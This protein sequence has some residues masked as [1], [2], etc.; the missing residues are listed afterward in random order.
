MTATR[1]ERPPA[2]E[3]LVQ[4]EL[5]WSPSPNPRKIAERIAGHVEADHLRTVLAGAL[6]Y[7]VQKIVARNR[8]AAA[9]V[10]GKPDAKALVSAPVCTGG[11][12]WSRYGDLTPAEVGERVAWQRE[13]ARRAEHEAL[14]LEEVGRRVADEIAAAV[15]SPRLEAVRHALNET[16]IRRCRVAVT[17]APGRIAEAQA[18]LRVAAES[19][20][21]AKEELAAETL[22]AEWDLDARFVTEANKTYLVEAPCQDPP[23]HQSAGAEHGCAERRRQ[24]TADERAKWKAAEAARAPAVVKAASALRLA[25]HAT[26]TARDALHVAERRFSAA[27]ADLAGAVAELQALGIGIANTEESR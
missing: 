6:T 21:Q 22:A 3:Q 27:K 23:A 25:E 12:K 7:A 19:E 26:A 16:G 5:A 1:V 13:I 18:A 2:V 24:M 15:R 20:R 11:R 8:A 10:A 17:E 14:R 9:G 4:E